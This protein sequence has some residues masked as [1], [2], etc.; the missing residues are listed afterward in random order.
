MMT[1]KPA[2]SYVRKLVEDKMRIDGRSFDQFRQI[3][4]ETGVIA[5]AEGSARVRIGNTMVIAGIKAEV[6][7]PFPDTP[8]EGYLVIDAEFVPLASPDFE[9]GPPAP[10]SI[11][12][13]RVVDRGI[14]E[15]HSIDTAA[16]CITPGEL[17]WGVHIDLH[18]LDHDGNLID[19]AALAAIAA[20]L[21]AKLPE[22]DM[23]KKQIQYGKWK[24]KLKMK[25]RPVEVTIGKI[26]STLLIDTTSEEETA[27]DARITIAT[28]TKGNLC[29]IQKGGNGFFTTAELETAVDMAVEK[30]KELRKLLPA[31]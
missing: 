20:L 26:G 2:E 5:N 4:V 29:A 28:N 21:T 31:L 10:E 6:R 3:Q 22:Y 11:E 27:L 23:E 15:S 24:D 30:G 12:L 25:D 13:A 19:A 8:N 14:R 17:V 18:V 9:P 7:E 1:L 16:L